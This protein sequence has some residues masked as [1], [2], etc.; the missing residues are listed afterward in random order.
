MVFLVRAL[1][2]KNQISALVETILGDLGL[3]R[4]PILV[5]QE[6]MTEQELHATITELQSG[7]NTL[8]QEWGQF[9]Q[10]EAKKREEDAVERRRRAD[11][12]SQRAKIEA[13]EWQKKQSFLSK[14]GVKIL[15]FF[16]LLA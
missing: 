13:E 3:A 14:H 15:S 4:V 9:L 6:M 7:M 10:A 5:R 1:V 12:E 16:N 2:L 11:S 8:T